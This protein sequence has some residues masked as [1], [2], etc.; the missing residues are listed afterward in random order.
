MALR[1]KLN[2]GLLKA[3]KS[4]SDEKLENVISI[5]KPFEEKIKWYKSWIELGFYI[6][7][8]TSPGEDGDFDT[9]MNLAKLDEEI[10]WFGG[11]EYFEFYLLYF[12]PTWGLNRKINNLLSDE[13]KTISPETQ[14][15]IVE[16]LKPF[17]TDIEEFETPFS[18]M[19]IKTATFSTEKEN[20]E[21][22]ENIDAE[23][24]WE[25][26]TE[27]LMAEYCPNIEKRIADEFERRGKTISENKIKKIIPI[28][29]PISK[30]EW[31]SDWLDD[32]ISTL[33]LA[34]SKQN[35]DFDDLVKLVDF[36][37]E[38]DIFCEDQ[39]FEENKY[40]YM[41]SKVIFR[42]E[43][44]KHSDKIKPA[45]MEE[46]V[47][48]LN[49]FLSNVFALTDEE[50]FSKSEWDEYW[51]GHG[52]SGLYLKCSNLNAQ[53]D[54]MMKLLEFDK[55]IDTFCGEEKLEKNIFKN[56][57]LEIIN[58]EEV[59]LLVVVICPISETCFSFLIHR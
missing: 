10:G 57:C 17:S 20:L 55:K 22:L 13:E 37:K 48:I 46:I 12:T 30:K 59:I 26:R 5:L 19:Y 4:I 32:G 45:E 6:L 41:S 23:F 18:T 53:F 24:G 8:L 28:L 56:K 49:P 9:L 38:N 15:T 39:K 43:I 29:E 54:D 44:S 31:D 11:W 27:K 14:Q 33:Y 50:D 42:A 1:E 36:D 47:S 34:C 40:K 58:L 2:D 35:S 3:G 25:T 51:F 7:Y 16:I 52:L 21:K